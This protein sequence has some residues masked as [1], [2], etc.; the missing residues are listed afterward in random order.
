MSYSYTSV[1]R[2]SLPDAMLDMTKEHL[3]VDFP[4]DDN[5]I[6]LYLAWAIAYVQNFTGLQVFG[7]NVAF[8]P[9]G[10]TYRCECPVKPVGKTFTAADAVGDVTADYLLTTA[11]L[12]ESAW[13]SRVDSGLVPAGVTFALVTGYE[14]PEEM[15]PA[16]HGNITRIAA[17]LYLNRESISSLSL[18]QVPFWMNDM[19]SGLWIPR[20]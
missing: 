11:S 5:S 20:A 8:K 3:R 9:A 2:S 15:D 4:D 18:D 1:D 19:L 12:T 7:A 16:L 14:D 13:L 6:K 10:G 17:T